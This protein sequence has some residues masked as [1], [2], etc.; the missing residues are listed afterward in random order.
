MK[1]YLSLSRDYEISVE[2]L[3]Q[4]KAAD[5]GGPT[6]TESKFISELGCVPLRW[7]ASGSAVEDYTDRGASKEQI[8]PCPYQTD[9]QTAT[10][11]GRV[12]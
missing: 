4:A 3:S 5:K 10:E 12:G 11:T 6:Y 2:T 8:N 7:S 1:A 9:R